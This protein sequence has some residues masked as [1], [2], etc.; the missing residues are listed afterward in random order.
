[1]HLS[2]EEKQCSW[3]IPSST[4]ISA[5]A[6]VYICIMDI[7]GDPE[8][9]MCMKN[10]RVCVLLILAILNNKSDHSSFNFFILIHPWNINLELEAN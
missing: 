4:G 7:L 6:I 3:K 5:F 10:L 2:S 1:M 9:I 8:N